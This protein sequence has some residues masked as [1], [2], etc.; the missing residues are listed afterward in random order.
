[1]LLYSKLNDHWVA[2]ASMLKEL[3]IAFITLLGLIVMIGFII[4]ISN[5]LL[6]P[7]N[8]LKFSYFHPP[9]AI[10]SIHNVLSNRTLLVLLAC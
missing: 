10:K 3:G 1:M 7:A 8:S 2:Y 5:Y 6:K 9:Q 4:D